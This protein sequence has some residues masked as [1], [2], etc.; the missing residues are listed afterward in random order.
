MAK[1]LTYEK[2]AARKDQAERFVRDV[3]GDDERA[4][5]IAE[6]SVED[7]AE[8]RRIQIQ[9]PQGKER[10][11]S[12]RLSSRRYRNT[13]GGT[14]DIG[15]RLEELENRNRELEEENEE[16]SAENERLQ[17][18]LDDIVNIASPDDGQDDDD[19]DDDQDDDDQDDDDEAA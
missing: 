1:T 18:R 7:Y 2:A 14:G 8:R 6:E 13:A 10:R 5:E 11:Q 17:S 16:L 12:M 19:Q 4:D 9:N 15:T 3:V